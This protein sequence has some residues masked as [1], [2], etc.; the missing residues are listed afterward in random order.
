MGALGLND[1]RIYQPGR[2]TDENIILVA[3]WKKCIEKIVAVYVALKYKIYPPQHQEHK[4]YLSAHIEHQGYSNCF[5]KSAYVM[6]R[7]HC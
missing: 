4:K 3:S 7:V 5:H 1:M 6:K 2:V